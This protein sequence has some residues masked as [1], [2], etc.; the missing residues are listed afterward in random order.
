M[1]PTC[2]FGPLGRIRPDLNVL[3]KAPKLRDFL[4]GDPITASAGVDYR[5]GIQSWGM[6]GNDRVGNCAEAAVLHIAMAQT[7]IVTGSP[8]AFADVDALEL[9]AAVTGFDPATG[10]G[11]NGTDLRTLLGFLMQNGYKDVKLLGYCIV[12]HRDDAEVLAAQTLFGPLL[13]GINLPRS[14]ENQTDVGQPWDLVP[15]SPI[16]GGH[17]IA[18]AARGSAGGIEITWGQEQDATDR[19]QETETDELYAPI[20]PLWLNAKGFSPTGANVDA[21]IAAAQ[22]YNAEAA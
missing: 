10:A 2:K 7:A 18:S 3:A 13:R 4:T 6:L 8:V 9:Y 1:L 15:W 11:D 5:G 12:N 17:A 19:F 16:I 21:L 20:S 22:Q 14:A